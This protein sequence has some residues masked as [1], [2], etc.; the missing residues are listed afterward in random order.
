MTTKRQLELMNR[1]FETTSYDVETDWR[2]VS[3]P[4]DELEDEG[5][6]GSLPVTGLKFHSVKTKQKGGTAA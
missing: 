4:E 3:L 5:E 1:F 6:G 2:S